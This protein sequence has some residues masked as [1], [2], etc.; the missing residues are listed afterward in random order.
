MDPRQVT[1]GD[2]GSFTVYSCS[3]QGGDEQGPRR[4]V[5]CLHGASHCACSWALFARL[6]RDLSKGCDVYCYDARGWGT[7]SPAAC[8]S[9]CPL[10][11]TCTHTCTSYNVKNDAEN[12]VTPMMQARID[13]GRR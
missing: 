5:L 9:S 1:V 12:M 13:Q 7:M 11:H 6:L 10:I 4:A 3:S 2:R 8:S